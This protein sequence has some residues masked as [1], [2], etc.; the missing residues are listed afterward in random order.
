MPDR[1]KTLLIVDDDEGMRDTMAAM[2]R[3][4]Y[5]ILRVATG[6][7]ALQV[8]QKENVDLM[9]LDVQLPGIGGLDVL[10]ILKENYPSIEVI[11]VS[12]MKDLDT[13]IEAMR[14]GAYHYLAKDFD[15]DGLRT[16][17]SNASERQELNR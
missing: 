11:V 1:R 9:L 13:A 3:Q 4:D 7:S 5:R 10:R 6:E 8:L 12:A 14:H 15:A 16:L 2:L 17:V